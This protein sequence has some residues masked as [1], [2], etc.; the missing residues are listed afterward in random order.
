MADP[1]HDAPPGDRRIRNGLALALL[2]SGC[3]LLAWTFGQWL[4]P[5]DP[6][7]G[8]LVPVAAAVAGILLVGGLGLVLRQ[9][10]GWWLLVG[11]AAL[12]AAS[13]LGWGVLAG[14]PRN[15]V[16]LSV[17]LGRHTAAGV[18]LADP[19]AQGH[20]DL[21]GLLISLAL[22]VALQHRAVRTGCGVGS[23]RRRPS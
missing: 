12:N 5:T 16:G 13:T 7:V 10:W 2:A 23:R 14:R 22:L 1:G 18:P 21:A 19:L 8:A 20:A 3:W 17:Q 4:V 11:G 6:A 15:P 9:A